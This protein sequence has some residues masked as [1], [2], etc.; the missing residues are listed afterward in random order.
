VDALGHRRVGAALLAALACTAIGEDARG[1]DAALAAAVRGAV[2]DASPA[3]VEQL[4]ADKVALLPSSDPA[5]G[6]PPAV[7]ALVLF[8][9][10]K[11][12]VMEFLLQTARQA[13]YRPELERVETVE[14]LAD[15]NLDEQE[16]KIMFVRVRYRL[17]YHWDP[18]ADR[19]VW[20]LDPS[21]DNGLHVIDGSWELHALDAGHTLARFST[22]VDV[23][24]ALPSFLQDIATRKN[25]PQTLERCRKWIDSDG[26]YRP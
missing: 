26:R 15:G 14:H 4:L 24:A 8:A 18:A 21:F 11:S 9:Q 10:P 6:E 7:R 2:P 12:R 20:K 22:H 1:D 5:P 16:M 17:R 13:E 25:V 23:G 19:V 3:L